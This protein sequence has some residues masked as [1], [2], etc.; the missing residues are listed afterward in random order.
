MRIKKQI[1][2]ATQKFIVTQRH[3]KTVPYILILIFIPL[4]SF[5]IL[6]M[7]VTTPFWSMKTSSWVFCC[8]HTALDQIYICIHICLSCLYCLLG[9]LLKENN[10]CKKFHF[11]NYSLCHS[12]H[13]FFFFFLLSFYFLSIH[14]YQTRWCNINH[15][16]PLSLTDD[17]PSESLKHSHACTVKA[18]KLKHKFH[19]LFNIL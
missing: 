3:L 10:V 13:I 14:H 11:S 8:N 9:L 17:L 5:N 18:K 12:S 1:I 16:L 15:K 2:I 19:Y 7:K 4:I 6:T